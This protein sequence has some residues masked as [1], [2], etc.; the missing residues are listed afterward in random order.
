MRVFICFSW[1]RNIYLP[2]CLVNNLPQGENAFI[3]E[4]D[5]KYTFLSFQMDSVTLIDL[6]PDPG[7][8]LIPGDSDFGRGLEGQGSV[9]LFFAF[10]FLAI[11]TVIFA[12]VSNGL[13]F[14]VFYKKPMFRK[15]LS[16]R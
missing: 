2:H 8:S 12:L 14:L 15:I 11:P 10:C 13:A 7:G 6:D 9:T 3:P 16:N 1:E 4:K 5:G